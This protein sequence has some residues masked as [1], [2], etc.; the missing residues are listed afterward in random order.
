M[1]TTKD[2]QL[3]LLKQKSKELYK[4]RKREKKLE[5]TIARFLKVL[6]EET[7]LIHPSN[8]FVKLQDKLAELSYYE[9]NLYI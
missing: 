7:E 5:N 1:K 2:K 9:G 6:T 8:N 3:D 4:L